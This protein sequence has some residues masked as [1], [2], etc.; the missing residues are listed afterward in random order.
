M[1]CEIL[2]NKYEK[3][4]KTDNFFKYLN[5]KRDKIINKLKDK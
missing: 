3:V 5:K 2:Q 4:Q 1:L